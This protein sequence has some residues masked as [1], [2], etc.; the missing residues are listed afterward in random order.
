LLNMAAAK[1][2][3]QGFRRFGNHS[4]EQFDE[5]IFTR[6]TFSV[7]VLPDVRPMLPDVVSALLG[8]DERSSSIPTTSTLWPT[9]GDSVLA[10]P[11]SRYD[12]PVVDDVVAAPEVPTGFERSLAVPVVIDER[13]AL[14][15]MKFG[16]PDVPVAFGT[17]LVA[18]MPRC[19]QPV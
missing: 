10:S 9:C 13:V 2:G 14:A 15:R 4:A 17:G 5:I 8:V 16:L 1:A 19:R 7:A 3:R 11:S 12:I 18:A 6:S